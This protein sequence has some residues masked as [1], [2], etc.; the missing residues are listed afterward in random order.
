[1]D[2][3]DRQPANRRIKTLSVTLLKQGVKEGNNK[4]DSSV[5][6]FVSFRDS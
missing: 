1:V 3:N 4:L 2:V 5:W 6:I